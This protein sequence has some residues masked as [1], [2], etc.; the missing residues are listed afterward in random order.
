VLAGYSALGGLIAA[1][2]VLY[3]LV[4]ISERPEPIGRARASSWAWGIPI[5][6]VVAVSIGL[7]TWS[8]WHGLLDHSVLPAPAIGGPV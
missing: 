3:A 5:G 8:A 2:V 1:A 4:Q 6:L 7:A